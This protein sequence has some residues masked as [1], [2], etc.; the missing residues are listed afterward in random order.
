[1]DVIKPLG[2][3]VIKPIINNKDKQEDTQKQ[4]QQTSTIKYGNPK[5]DSPTLSLSEKPS[6]ERYQPQQTFKIVTILTYTN[7]NKGKRGSQIHGKW[8]ES[9]TCKVR[10]IS[11]LCTVKLLE[12]SIRSVG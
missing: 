1:M 11:M 3:D 2:L 7:L 9:I 6:V 8:K 10:T 4:H 12:Q 5:P